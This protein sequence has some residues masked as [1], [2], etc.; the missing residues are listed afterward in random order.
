MCQNL[1]KGGFPPV[2]PQPLEKFGI[3]C[4]FFM[5]ETVWGC[6][7]NGKG[8]GKLYFSQMFSPALNEIEIRGQ[9]IGG[10]LNQNNSNWSFL[11]F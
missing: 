6:P 1:A 11:S 4:G 2:F 10:H 7:E 8:K 9:I 5:W 3:F